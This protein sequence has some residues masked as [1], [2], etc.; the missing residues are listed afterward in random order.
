PTGT[1]KVSIKGYVRL[2]GDDEEILDHSNITVSIYNLANLDQDI[3]SINRD[4]P[5]IGVQISQVT[6]FDHRSHYPIA[7]GLTDVNGSFEIKDIASGTYNFVA[8][9]EGW[10]FIYKH[11]VDIEKGTTNI[12]TYNEPIFL[13]PEVLIVNNVFEEMILESNRH[14]IFEENTV[15]HNGSHLVIKPGTVLRIN[16]LRS[17]TIMGGLTAEYLSGEYFKVTSND[18]FHPVNSDISNYAN[19]TIE[20]T[21]SITNNKLSGGIFS[22]GNF[23]IILKTSGIEIE[24][25]IFNNKLTGCYAMQIND[26]MIN[27]VLFRGSQDENNAS[28]YTENMNDSI[29]KNSIFANNLRGARIQNSENNLLTN[30]YFINNENI[31]LLHWF[32]SNNVIEESIF[33]NTQVGI[34]NSGG[35]SVSI[36]RN[37]ISAV[38]GVNNIDYL[39]SGGYAFPTINYNNFDCSEY[40]V[41]TRYA[42]P[43]RYHDATHNYWG[44][45]VV[46]EIEELIWDKN[47]EPETNTINNAYIDYVPFLNQPYEGAGIQEE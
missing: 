26:V 32:Y 22:F 11:N 19:V 21:A 37:V 38:I 8:R 5:H 4:Y 31:S 46:S 42:G 10:G 25:V 12:S 20:S 27:R 29:V 3:A 34:L 17:I 28:L 47:D 36:Q 40:A 7:S 6:E 15:F 16:P 39:S 30:N 45:T 23:G 2:V 14:Y 13:Y 1:A 35:S 9:K 44:T 18:G 24:N 33:S 43:I 41:R